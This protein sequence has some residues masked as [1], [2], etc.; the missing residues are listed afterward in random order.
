MATRS[1][2]ARY[3]RATNEYTAIYCHW[4]GYPE[5]VGVTLRDHYTD[6]FMVKVLVNSGGLSTL[7]NTLATNV[8]LRSNHE[9]SIIFT[10]FSQMA[11]HYQ[12]MWC[13]YGYVWI[14]GEWECYKLEPT[15]IN[16]YEM[17][18]A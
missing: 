7:E 12:N 9:P 11:M 16:L 13:E 15:R 10:A 18:T 5:G 3:D 17:E 1:F 2:I 8:P 4:D 6:D 14:D